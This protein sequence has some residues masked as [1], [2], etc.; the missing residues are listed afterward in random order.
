MQIARGLAAAH[1]K[2]IVHRDLK[3]ENLFVTKD[4]RVKILD[5]GLAKLTQPQS[6]SEH[7]APTFTEGTE[8]GRGDG[9]GGLHVAGAGAGTIGRP[10]GRHLRF[11]RDSV[12]DAGGQT[13]VSEADLAGDHDGDLERRA[14]G[15][16]AGRAEHSAGIAAGGASLSGKEPG[17]ALSVGFRSG[18]RAGR[19]VGLW[20]VIIL[21][22]C[23]CAIGARKR[24]KVIVPATVM[25]LALSV[26]SYFY[27]H[28]TPNLTDKDTVVLT[29]FANSTGDP[30]FDD[31]LK[32]ALNISLR[33]SPFLNFVP[34]GQIAETLHMMARPAGTRLTPEV[35]RELCQRAHAKAMIEGAIGSL[36][37]EYVLGLK[38]VACQSGDT[39]AQEQATAESKDKVVEALGELA[40]K[41]RGE[42]GES[43]S[44][45][46]RFDVPLAY[47]TTPSLD[48]LKQYSLAQ[49]AEYEKGA[50]ASVPYL[51]HA[52]ELDPNFAVGYLM[53]GDSYASMGEMARANEYLTKAF[54]LR[55]HANEREK[56]QIGGD[57]YTDVTG[58]LDQAAKTFQEEIEDYPGEHAAYGNL[59]VVYAEQG[60]YDRAAEITRQCIRV[61]PGDTAAYANLSGYLLAQ[62]RFGESRQVIQ[63][64]L[65]RK[66]DNF[67]FHT[68][69]Y[70]LAFLG[71]DPAAMTEQQ[72]W[73]A[74][75]P[76]YE[77][78][79]LSLA[80]DTEAYGGRQGKARELT[81]QTVDSAIRDDNKESGAIFQAIAAQ[82]EAVYG[83]AAEAMNDAAEALKLAPTSEGAESEAGLALALAGDTAKAESVAQ[84]LEQRFPLDTQM[85]MLWLPAIRAQVA[86]D[87]KNA[88][89]AETAVQAPSD[90]ELG[91]ISFV[92]NVSC[93]YSVYV[94]GESYLAAGQGSAAAAEFQRILDHGGIVWNCWTGA[95]AR[96][97]VA[98]ANAMEA[99]AAQ[100]ADADAARVRALAAYRDFLTLW[101][102]ADLGIPILIAAKAE[103]ARLQ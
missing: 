71:A 49:R 64:A 58:E 99:G 28:R 45:V 36:G 102:E 12:R 32:T 25:V 82:R 21:E 69:L 67:G 93:L 57:Y 78:S 79:G 74:I 1:E 100:G 26:G 80:S 19:A 24:W 62:Q 34:Q 43:L 72:K 75:Q 92:P 60:Q 13:G 23:E 90:A 8:A 2:G 14:A 47:A 35:A 83:N 40:T 17:A 96:L 42:L 33:Q 56:L 50:A 51:S 63:E 44:T 10:S 61:F 31:T 66:T 77:S 91:T 88:A 103:Y 38:A 29:D 81:R 98:R 55:D 86:L 41:L 101:K 11:R 39:L 70:A 18:V 6:S 30:I 15:H 84:D 89:A 53:L 22:G 97:G 52:I 85:Q 27:F 87:R 73:F 95:L 37:S 48:A 3:P 9:H 68:S 7:S 4:G 94:R 5:F 59:G 46:Q 65:A 76:D 20:G 54:Q 16:F